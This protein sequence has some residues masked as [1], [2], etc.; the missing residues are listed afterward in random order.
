M[1]LL[2]E[3]YNKKDIGQYRDDGLSVFKN[4]SGQEA[5]KIKKDLQNIFKNNGLEIVIACNMVVVTYFDITLNLDDGT[6]R[7][8]HKPNGEIQY[9]HKESNHPAT[10]IKQLPLTIESRLSNISSSKEIFDDSV[11]IY[12]IVEKS[13][14]SSHRLTY[15]PNNSKRDGIKRDRKRNIIWFNPPYS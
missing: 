3:K 9:I 11:K 1:S 15:K 13:G 12:E 8:Y 7:P 10:I 14:F 4:I 5:E 6:Y 2:G